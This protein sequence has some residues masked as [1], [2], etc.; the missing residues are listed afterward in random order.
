MKSQELVSILLVGLCIGFIATFKE[1]LLGDVASAIPT[2]LGAIFVHTLFILIIRYLLNKAHLNS[3]WFYS[4]FFIGIGLAIGIVSGG[5][6]IFF[7]PSFV[8]IT[9]TYYSTKHRFEGF[10][11]R[12]TFAISLGIVSLV[13]IG[14]FSFYFLQ[15]QSVAIICFLIVFYSLIPF[16]YGLSLLSMFAEYV[17]FIGEKVRELMHTKKGMNLGSIL[18]HESFYT[19]IFLCSFVAFSIISLFSGGFWY[20]VFFAISCACLSVSLVFAKNELN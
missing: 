20:S 15:L 1:I 5:K 2:V 10:L 9:S 14:F 6:I 13:L 3:E 12:S 7:L 17:P 8:H 11:K 16:D 4:P 18:I 19:Y